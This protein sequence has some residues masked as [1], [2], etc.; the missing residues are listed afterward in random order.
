MYI[1]LQFLFQRILEV[2]I[3]PF[4]SSKRAKMIISADNSTPDLEHIT[5][6]L[7]WGHVTALQ[8]YSTTSEKWCLVN[9]TRR[10]KKIPRLHLHLLNYSGKLSIK[11]Q[12]SFLFQ[13]NCSKYVCSHHWDYKITQWPPTHITK[14]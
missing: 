9:P 8:S 12:N 6:D 7:Y 3:S 10:T 1:Y 14:A 13:Y 4:L 5:A 2:L 11:I